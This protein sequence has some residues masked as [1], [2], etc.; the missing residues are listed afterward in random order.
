MKEPRPSKSSRSAKTKHAFGWVRDLPDTRDVV[1]SAPLGV[2]RALPARVDLR[3]SCPP[4]L[5]QGAL[6]SCTA[7][8]IASAH[9]FS[10]IKQAI[11]DFAPSRLFIYYNERVMIDSVD[12]DSGARIRDGFKSVAKQGV[13]PER[14]W[15]YVIGKFKQKPNNNCYRDALDHQLMQYLKLTQHIS[16][17]KGCLADGFPFVFGCMLYD[18]FQRVTGNGIVPLPSGS[19]SPIGGHAMLAVGYDDKS[20]SF[21]VQ[22]SWGTG[23]G[24]SGY[25][26]MPYSYLTDS[27]L[28]SD[29]WTMRLVEMNP[30]VMPPARSFALRIGAVVLAAGVTGK[31]IDK[32]EALQKTK[33]MLVREFGLAAEPS[34]GASLRDAPPG[35]LGKGDFSIRAL[36]VPIEG[37]DFKDYG[38]EVI[39]QNLVNAKTVATLRDAI[40]EGIPA[41]HKA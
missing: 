30:A 7:N 36:E 9:Q 6:G 20:Q 37:H 2:L 13:C 26:Y 33:A 19:E 11:K 27:S 12:Y 15:A 23:W 1:Y 34:S 22:N 35:G 10:Q 32:T 29:F 41:V 18:A 14:S 8:A 21:I 40:W 4:V 5:D 31:K 16:Q 28:S 17:L 25:S 3:D 39:G 24:D 38:A